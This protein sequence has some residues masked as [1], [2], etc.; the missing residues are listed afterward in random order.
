MDEL[1]E[2]LD[3]QKSLEAEI[4]ELET[5]KQTLSKEV[6]DYEEQKKGLEDA[7]AALKYKLNETREKIKELRE[8]D[9]SKFEAYKMAKAGEVIAKLSNTLTALTNED[10]K[11]Q[12]LEV[13]QQKYATD[14]LDEGELEN[15]LLLAY[16]SLKPQELKELL[17]VKKTAETAK[18]EFVQKAQNLS[19][20]TTEEVETSEITQEDII[21]AAQLGVSPETIARMRKGEQKSTL[22]KGNEPVLEY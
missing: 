16:M 6:S 19:S 13:W 21:K 1:Q 18:Q 4:Q 17:N 10:V 7:I 22:L 2:L 12:V 20:E 8:Q 3:K 11:K 14:T 9:Q 5:K 15:Q